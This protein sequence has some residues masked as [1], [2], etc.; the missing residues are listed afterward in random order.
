MKRIK[1]TQNQY[2]IVDN[3]DFEY[4]NQFK[5]YAR[6]ETNKYYAARHGNIGINKY[7]KIRMHREIINASETEYVDHINGNTL[8]NRKS[9]LRTCTSSQNSM[10]RG[11]SK[12]NKSGYKGVYLD[13]RNNS[14]YAQICTKGKRYTV[15]CFKTKIDAAVA[16]N[17]LAIK[18]HRA[19][20]KLN[21]IESDTKKSPLKNN[22]HNKGNT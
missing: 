6:N 10:N 13:K 16:Y 11:K 14:W 19:F 3:E 12:N 21:I 20:A 7:K 9:N 17:E 5:W 18:H 1:L 8:D 4:L 22:N 2:A 15:S